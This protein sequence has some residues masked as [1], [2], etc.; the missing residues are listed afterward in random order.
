LFSGRKPDG[1]PTRRNL[2]NQEEG[3]ML[4]SLLL[5]LFVGLFLGCSIT[6]GRQF[7]ATAVNNIKVGT[8]TESEVISMLGV[9]LSKEKMSN[10][11]EL[12]RYAYGYRV[13]IIV[14][15][16]VNA[17]QLQ[18]CEGVVV[19]KWPRLYSWY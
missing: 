16:K 9:P 15:T 19:N 2:L 1:S 13:P 5:L 17:L 8:T 12:Y 7:N 18:I 4:K 11:S 6:A 3:V 10:G 14:E